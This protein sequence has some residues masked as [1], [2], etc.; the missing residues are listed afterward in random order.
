MTEPTLPT[1]IAEFEA[2]DLGGP[3]P[4]GITMLQASAGT[5]KTF[6]LAAL[7][8]RSIAELG[9]SASELCV[10]TFT[11]AATSELRGRIRERIAEAVAHL[12]A[13]LSLIHI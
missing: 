4:T 10:V 6:A 11:E 2:F 13:G 8:V 3:L 1:A 12:E 5:G 7:A 9:L